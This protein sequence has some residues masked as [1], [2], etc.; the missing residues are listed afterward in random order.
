MRKKTHEEYVKELED[1]NL[2][3]DVV[4]KY[5]NCR[6]KIYHRCKTCGHKW[7]VAPEYILDESG[8]PVCSHKAIGC[9]P[10]Y[11]NSIWASEYRDFYS[12][13]LSE[14]EMKTIMPN[15]AKKITI[16]CQH[17][18]YSKTASVYQF[19][20]HGFACVCDDGFSFPNKF[21]FSVLNQL[22]IMV[23]TEYSPI[24]ANHKRYDLYLPEYNIIVEN[25]GIQ[26]YK[27]VSSLKFRP[28]G[29]ERKND[30]YKK[31]L[32]ITNGVLDY[33]VLDCRY[34][35]VEWIKRSIMTS[36]LPILFSFTEND[37]NW[38]SALEYASN[39][40]LYNIV[41]LFQM[42]DSLP[43]IAQQLNVSLWSIRK[44]LK[45][46]TQLNLCDYDPQACKEK[47]Y[48]RM[49]KHQIEL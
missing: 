2:N 4:E 28:L 22:N 20:K 13:Y 1:K 35:T 3:F 6:T 34:S 7:K 39:S 15:S 8:C 33:I 40:L 24:W 16:K 17:C 5:I 42:E 30:A 37:I 45:I 46:G 43:K 21:V 14:E 44:Y 11:K 49:R 12:K 48:E 27:E 36:K 26:H 32:A 25:H 18:G 10:E 41:S 31:E 23:Q 19:T 47:V 38:S 29:E 9:A